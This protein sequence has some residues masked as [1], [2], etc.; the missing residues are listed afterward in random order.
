M[1]II[2]NQGFRC[3]EV[4]N[5]VRLRFLMMNLVRL[6]LTLQVI[7]M[8]GLL[9]KFQCWY[10]MYLKNLIWMSGQIWKVNWLR[11]KM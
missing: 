7:V 1:V 3:S 8:M 6:R 10:R 11:K 5:A 2:T 4:I 9:R